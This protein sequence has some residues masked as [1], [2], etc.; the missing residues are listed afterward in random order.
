[1][2]EEDG[3]GG[4]SRTFLLSEGVEDCRQDPDQVFWVSFRLSHNMRVE[5]VGA[6]CW[7][8]CLLE[9]PGL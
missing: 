6:G 5:V 7:S 2:L 1:M 9:S 4:S 3:G 8:S